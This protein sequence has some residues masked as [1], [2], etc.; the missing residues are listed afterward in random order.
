MRKMN[1][2]WRGVGLGAKIAAECEDKEK[3]YGAVH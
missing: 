2:H 3:S 1:K